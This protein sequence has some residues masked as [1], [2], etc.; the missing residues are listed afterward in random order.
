MPLSY[1][2]NFYQT[3]NESVKRSAEIIVPLVLDVVKP[4]SVI[5]IGCG[6]GTWLSV[7]QKYGVEDIL[8]VDGNYVEHD[9][10]DIPENKF[11]ACDL[12]KELGIER[13]FDLT[14]SLEVAEHLPVECAESFVDSLTQFAPIVLFS[15]AIP[16][17]GGTNH[18]NEQWPD[19]WAELF[20][21]REFIPS[22]YIRKR[23]WNN[24]SVEKWYAQNTLLFIKQD[25][26]ISFPLLKEEI[27]QEADFP[28]SIVH[29]REY[30][31]KLSVLQMQLD[32]I[33]YIVDMIPPE[34]T[35][36]LVDDATLGLE[37]FP[38][39]HA[40]PFL[41]KNGEYWGAPPDDITAIHELERLRK[42]GAN[43]IVIIRPAF[44]WINF[45]KEFYSYLNSSFINV[46]R[47]EYLIAFD[48]RT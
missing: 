33:P 12:Q 10:L 38:R 37:V 25:K 44:W 41:E 16:F 22:N 32:I 17:Q 4:Q 2:R 24:T 43:F 7:F 36:I 48:L 39:R 27:E 34:N 3:L 46:M 15:A 35:F 30:T 14:V 21:Q 26:L 20:Q 1:S 18:I 40:L 29:P 9:M 8:G 45:Y 31:T 5:D 23:I 28:L 47:N 6:T 42:A 13:Q 11:I 19:Y